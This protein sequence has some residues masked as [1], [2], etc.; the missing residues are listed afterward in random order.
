LVVLA[1]SLTENDLLASMKQMRFYA[2]QDYGAQITFK[3]NNQPLGS[4]MTD[5]SA[6]IITVNAITS[7]AVISIKIWYGVPGSGANP[8]VITTGNTATLSYTDNALANLATGYYY[9]DITATDG[10]RTI[11]API[12]YTRD[13]NAALPITLTSFTAQAAG[14]AVYIKWSTSTEINNNYF[15]LERS[16][17]G[18]NFSKIAEV[19]GFGNSNVNQNYQVLDTKAFKGINYYRLRQTD[20]DGKNTVSEIKAVKIITGADKDFNIYPNPVEHELAVALTSEAN[21]L[22]L[23]VIGTDGK[24]SIQGTGTVVQLNQL[25]NRNLML[26]KAGIYIIKIENLNESYSTKMIKK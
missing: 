12:W 11:T 24:I 14:S 19:K 6:P 2:T 26:L 20:F 22:N 4:I 8:T 15:T 10:T 16:Q 1:P 23:K 25:I 21:D 13:D 17:D 9:T 3:I 18:K 7:S 5:R